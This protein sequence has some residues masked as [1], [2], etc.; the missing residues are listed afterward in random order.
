MGTNL[1]LVRHAHSVYTPDER[2]RPLSERGCLDAK[3]V[4]NCSSGKTSIMSYQVRTDERF[5]P[6]KA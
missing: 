3:K 4:S 2:N 6:S 1:Y 5:K